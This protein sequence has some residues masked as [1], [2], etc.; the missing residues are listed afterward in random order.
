MAVIGG[1]FAVNASRSLNPFYSFDGNNCTVPTTIR[2]T[3]TGVTTTILLH[4][5][6]LPVS[7]DCQIAVK[8]TA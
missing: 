5:S 7:G 3:T 6:S 1:A 4:Y 2:F 8:A